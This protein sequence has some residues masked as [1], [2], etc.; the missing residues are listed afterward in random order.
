LNLLNTHWG[1]LE[2]PTGST[3]ATTSQ[4]SLLSQVGETAGPGAQPIY[5]F[6]ATMP[7]YNAD[8]L[9]TYYQIQLAI[10]YSF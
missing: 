5:R 4:I 6:D 3:L 7:R 10:R 8:N 1:R 2:L 9:D